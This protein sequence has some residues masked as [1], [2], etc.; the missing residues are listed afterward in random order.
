M[1]QVDRDYHERLTLPEVDK[2]LDR[3]TAGED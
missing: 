3:L 2:I 1:M